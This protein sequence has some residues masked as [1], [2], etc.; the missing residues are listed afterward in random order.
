MIATLHPLFAMA[1]LDPA[2][3]PSV[4]LGAG[5]IGVRT[6]AN[7]VAGSSPAMVMRMMP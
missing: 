5:I 4:P 3:H 7:W 6:R 2:T 1:G